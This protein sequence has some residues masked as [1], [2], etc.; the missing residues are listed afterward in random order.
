MSDGWVL[1]LESATIVVLVVIL[2]VRMAYV[3]YK[4]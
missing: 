2:F 1:F 4:E 3:N